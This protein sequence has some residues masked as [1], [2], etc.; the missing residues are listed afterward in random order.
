MKTSDL[1]YSLPKE[2][3]AQEPMAP[4]E[5]AKLLYIERK[6]VKREHLHVADLPRFLGP[7]D[8]LVL[9][10]TSVLRARIFGKLER[11]GN[12]REVFLLRNITEHKT[13]PAEAEFSPTFNETPAFA[14]VG[15]NN[16]WQVLTRG[17]VKI[18]DKILFD[19][20]I[21]AVVVQKNEDATFIMEFS[22][23]GKEFDDFV[24]KFGHVPIPPYI[25]REP[26]VGEYETVFAD[27]NE[28]RSAAAPTAGFHLTKKLLAELQQKGVQI[29]K[30]ILD[31]GLG[32]FQSIKT[33]NLEDHQI[34]A[35]KIYISEETAKRINE[36][37]KNGKRV[38]AVGT[39]TLRVLESVANNDG[40]IKSFVGETKLFIT[41]GYKFK[42][43][44]ALL[45]NFH[46]PKSSL[47]AL[48]AA[49]IGSVDSTLNI[50][51][52]AVENRYRFFSFGDAMFIE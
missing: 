32:T 50:Y 39:T 42:I 6:T 51:R 49:F 15:E 20:G 33:E 12:E 36:A 26:G 7:N 43:V 5:A 40:T 28:R 27:P 47:L 1:D 34:H 41:P 52:E 22:C 45:T 16:R 48:V 44:D 8:C 21:F 46:L 23:A 29:E 10:V 9:N 3:I 18:G 24:A 2:L 17:S 38:V 25:H 13:I 35:E 11:T 19:K 30:V 14:G 37:K 31:V 4:R